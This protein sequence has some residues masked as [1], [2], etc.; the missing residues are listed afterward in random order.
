MRLRN[1][2]A[3]ATAL[4]AATALSPSMARADQSAAGGQAVTARS[5]TATDPAPNTL[6]TACGCNL[7]WASSLSDVANAAMTPMPNFSDQYVAVTKDGRLEHNIQSSHLLDWQGWAALSQPGVTVT[8]ASIAGMPDGSAQVVEVLSSGAVLHN[9]RYANGSWQG[10]GNPGGSHIAQIS[11]GAM[12]DGSAQLVAVTTSGTLEHNV[13]YA[14]GSW[15][16]WRIPAQPAA[17]VKSAGIAGVSDGSSQLI[18]VTTSGVLEHDV[19]HADGSWQGWASPGGGTVA[20]AS[21]VGTAIQRTNGNNG[22][23]TFVTA[24]TSAGAFEG[25]IRNGIGTW[26][27]WKDF[28]TSAVGPVSAVGADW[29]DS[30]YIAIAAD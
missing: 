19:R 29:F 20:Q 11:I 9:I 13:R 18:A 4:L 28:D 8:D 6:M 21:I 16:G 14:N 10:W 2:A 22:T 23:T 30:R 27:G 25:D 15:Q 5:F 17:P 12:P 7:P 26:D 24:V 3:T 1:I